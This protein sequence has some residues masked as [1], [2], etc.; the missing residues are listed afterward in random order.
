MWAYLL[1]RIED[2]RNPLYDIGT[3]EAAHQGYG[4]RACACHSHL[5]AP[6]RR[7]CIRSCSVCGRPCTAAGSSTCCRARQ[8]VT[9]LASNLSAAERVVGGGAPARAVRERGPSAP[10]VPRARLSR[11]PTIVA[12]DGAQIQ[13]REAE[14]VALRSQVE[15]AKALIAAGDTAAVRDLMQQLIASEEAAAQAAPHVPPPVEVGAA[16]AES[17]M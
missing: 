11:A 12:S 3:G 14:L 17:I 16:H 8:A 13:S 5:Q 10:A 9:L 15:R 7:T 6:W 2:F 4:A 1:S